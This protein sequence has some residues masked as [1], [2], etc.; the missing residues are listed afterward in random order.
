MEQRI[1]LDNNASTPLDPAVL[2]KLIHD[3][4]HYFGNPSSTH[5]FG[6]EAKARLTQARDTIAKYLCVRPN[7]IVFTSGATEGLNAILRGLALDKPGHII[8]SDVEHSCVYSTLKELEKLGN[9]VSY[10]QAGLHGS[11]TSE[12]VRAAIRQDTRFVAVMAV[13]NET[14]VKTDL[15]GIAEVCLAYR[16]PLIVDG[17]AMLGKEIIELHPGISAM[18][19]S[20][21]KL[22]A[23][24]GVG[25]SFIRT[26]LKFP[27]M[28]TGGEQEML[29]RGGTENMS[30][31]VALAEA[32]RVLSRE[33][34]SA[35]ER[36]QLLRDRFEKEVMKNCSFVT[37]N[38]TGPRIVNT[39]NLAFGE[40]DGESLLM[41]MD[42]LGLA[43]SHGSACS[44]GALEPSRVLLN[45]GIPLK[46]ARS[47]IRFSLSRFTTEEE[48]AKAI[49]IIIK[50]V[51]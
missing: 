20:G 35:K 4:R 27:S 40:M 49:E 18:C 50:A 29:R 16:V 30:G 24:K 23:P 5:S 37:V 25:F 51:R 44:S 9:T 22:H 45:M 1:Y 6:R 38:G 15:K 8:S 17:V 28:V 14:G 2:D 19:F 41:K 47:S 7:E 34:P 43:A 11:I 36:M 32:V 3:Q 31:I 26:Q 46:L 12:A 10:L 21:H 42:M 39:S 33:L 13:N 48:I